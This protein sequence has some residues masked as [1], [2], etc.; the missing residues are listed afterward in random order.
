MKRL[1]AYKNSLIYIIPVIVAVVVRKLLY[2]EWLSSPF[3]YYH[4]IFGLD[5]R[6]FLVWGEQLYNGHSSFRIYKFFIAILYAFFG[7]SALPETIV[8]FQMIL[9]VMTVFLTV[10]IFRHLFRSKTG[11]LI[12][13]LFSALYAPLMVYE[14]HI[15]KESLFLFLSLLSF[16]MFLAARKKHFNNLT[17]YF[18][19]L[20]AV[21]PFFLRVSGLLLMSLLYLWMILYCYRKKRFIKPL[22]FSMLGTLTIVSIIFIYNISHG[23]SIVQYFTP[24]TP[25]LL[26]VGSTP[27]AQNLSFHVTGHGKTQLVS[28][29]FFTYIR[30]YASKLEYIFTA[31]EQPNN[32]NYYFICSKLPLL[33]YYI[34]PFFLIP[35]SVSGFILLLFRYRKNRRV[36]L[37]FIYMISFIVP[38]LLFLP[39]ARYKIALTPIFAIFAA[40]WIIYM[41]KLFKLGD[42]QRMVAPLLICIAA[43]LFSGYTCRNNPER[44]SDQSAYGLAA[45]YMPDKLMLAGRY[46]QALEMLEK[47]YFENP[48]NPYIMLNYVSSLMGSGRVAD[49]E[50]V[51]LH[52]Q[53]IRDEKLL[54]RYFYEL[55][56]STYML[57]NPA[58]A[59]KYYNTA[60]TYPISDQRRKL[61]VARIKLISNK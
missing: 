14:T 34:G 60:I 13:G 50:N 52:T 29:S 56:E 61:A 17:A 3:R 19:G 57:N 37:L 11:A 40:W 38:M 41:I 42:K 18:A 32:I 46:Q 31:Y 5:M 30:T 53:H 48:E 10:Y 16:S 51:L 23:F 43:F 26:G 45:S 7:K 49:A 28:H 27:N 36:I 15:L 39:L 21:L 54:G 55:G 2:I 9:G 58:Q 6:K 8:F 47:N 4:T 59:L 33:K 25:Y 22:L 20:T 1:L 44:R 12:A 35:I 24:N